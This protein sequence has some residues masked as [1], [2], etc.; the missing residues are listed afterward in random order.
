MPCVLLSPGQ[1]RAA[2]STGGARRS[3]RILS[4]T[5]LAPPPPRSEA[6]EVAAGDP[7][8]KY[9]LGSVLNHV[10]LHQTVGW[11]GGGAGGRVGGWE[12]ASGCGAALGLELN[13]V[14]LPRA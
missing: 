6:V 1:P 11:A 9:A 12:G 5:S 10:L 2:G 13:H 3:R 4:P 7:A 8:A 14:R